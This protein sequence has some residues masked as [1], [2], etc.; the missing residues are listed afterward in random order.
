MDFRPSL[1]L[2]EVLD[3]T[4][5]IDTF[6]VVC[7]NQTVS[8]GG[9]ASDALTTHTDVYGIVIPNDSINLIVTEE[10]ERISGSITIYTRHALTDGRKSGRDADLVRWGGREFIVHSVGPWIHF[11]Q[12]WTQAICLLHTVNPT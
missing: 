6:D 1:D 2:T 12:G 5:F 9:I 7:R 10:G 4:E 3:S 8:S 11:G